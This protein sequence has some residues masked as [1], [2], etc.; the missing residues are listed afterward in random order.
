M[1]VRKSLNEKTWQ[2]FLKG[3]TFANVFQTPEMYKVFSSTKNYEPILVAIEEGGDIKDIV[4]ASL[5][6]EGGGLKGS[7]SARAIVTGGPLSQDDDIKSLLVEFDEI[8][9]GKAL[10]SQFRNLRDTSS[11]HQIFQQSGYNFEEHL[12]YTHN[13]TRSL[14]E[15][16]AGFSDGR[17]KGI[18][19]AESLGLKVRE[20]DKSDLD[21][22]YGMVE[23]TYK[24]A[25][26]PLADKSLFEAA[27][28]E[29][30]PKKMILFILGSLHK[31]ILAGRMVLAYNGML[32]DWYAGSQPSAR[33]QNANEF[34]VW[35]TMKWGHENGFSL[36]DFG[37]AGKPGEQ[38]GPGEFKRR[39]GGTL[40]NFGRFQKIYHPIKHMIGRKGYELLRRVG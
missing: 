33:S 30:S 29:L 1:K 36:F 4:L 32:H 18:K 20:G 2:H 27:F 17:K 9:R 19:K 26:V 11:Y 31:N 15:I 34:L 12:N 6:K 25:G 13:L 10:Y 35:H 39:F 24:D 5:I 3:V 40:T 16:N 8:T 28:R 38:Y 14:K 23:R 21:D 7:M 22:F 37:G